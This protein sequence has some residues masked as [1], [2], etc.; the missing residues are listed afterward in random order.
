MLLE[1][2]AMKF[3]L[4]AQFNTDSFVLRRVPK[5]VYDIA[6]TL[7]YMYY[8]ILYRHILARLAI[9]ACS[10]YNVDLKQVFLLSS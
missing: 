4:L 5:K 2:T 6:H 7:Y 8:T 9:L 3:C 10:D 1:N